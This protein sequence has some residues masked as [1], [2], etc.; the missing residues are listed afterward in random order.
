MLVA[1][2]REPATAG[3][4]GTP[5]AWY[6][7]LASVASAQKCGGVHRKI[8]AASAMAVVEIV[9][10]TAAQPTSGGNDP[11]SPPMTMLLTVRRLSQSVYTKTYH[12]VPPMVRAAA[13]GLVRWS[14]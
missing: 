13:R 8:T 5:A 6:S 7:S 2:R 11:A 4:I 3:S 1:V 12:S 14:I 9:P 10:V